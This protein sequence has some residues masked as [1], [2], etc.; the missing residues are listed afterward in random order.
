MSELSARPLRPRSG[1]RKHNCPDPAAERIAELEKENRRLR[2]HL[3]EAEAIVEV[4]K[5]SDLLGIITKPEN[6]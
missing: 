6:S 2:K 4:Q 3:Q 1:G 5:I